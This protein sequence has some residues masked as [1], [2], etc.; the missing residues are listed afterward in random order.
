MSV[1]PPRPKG[2]PLNALRAFEAAARLGG[3]AAAA[4][5]LLV[6]PGAVAQ[7]VRLLE[8]W[9][10]AR[11]F[12]RHAQ[13]VRLTPLGVEAA[14]AYGAAF[15]ALGSATHSLRAGAAPDTVRIATLP[16]LAQLWLSPRLPHI[17]ATTGAIIS[18]SAIE[19]P[20]NLNR[21]QFDLAI[22]FAEAEGAETTTDLGPD[23]IFP[24]CAPPLAPKVRAEG[25]GKATLLS[26]AAW[27][28]DW[29]LWS[30]G[31]AMPDG[32]VFSLYA[33]AISEAVA[34]AGVVMG[35]EHLVRHLLDEGS[36]IAPFDHKVQTGKRLTLSVAAGAGGK[37]VS[38]ATHLAGG[39]E[40]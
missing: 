5:E 6:T 34:G 32:P 4:E 18:V 25:L 10:G 2:P 9:A 30:K 39:G 8:E 16:G 13:G 35:H 17:R 31:S 40:T 20:P 28:E 12:I 36:L 11:L 27:T 3:F 1:A 29:A 21:A 15:D 26:D 14:R 38:V 19:T 22:F 24:V 37:A 33:L 7:Q 23:L